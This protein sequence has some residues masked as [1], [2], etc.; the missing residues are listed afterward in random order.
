MIPKTRSI[1]ALASLAGAF[2]LAFAPGAS[3]KVVDNFDDNVK[4]GWTDA[5]FGIGSATETG[6]QLVFT[7]PAVQ[8]VFFA[9][10][11]NTEDYTLADGKTIEL[12]VDMISANRPDAY[13]ILA[14]IP[15]SVDVKSLAGYSIT[16]SPAAILV[17]K[18]INKY[19]IQEATPTLKQNNVTMVLTL[20][21]KGADVIINVKVLDKDANNAVVYEK[22]VIDTPAADALAAG[23]DSPAAPYMGAGKMTLM[24]YEDFNAGGDA[25]YT[26]TFDNAESFVYENAVIDDFNAGTKTGWTDASFGVGSS[27]VANGQFAFTI[28]AVQDVFFASLKN[29]R[30]YEFK[31]GEKLEFRVDLISGSRPDAYAIVSFTPDSVDPKSLQGYGFVK[32]S[33]AIL[34]SKGINKYFYQAAHPDIKNNNVTL[35]LNLERRGTSVIINTRIYDLEANNAVLFD[36]TFVDTDAADALAAGTDSP[37]AAYTGLGKFALMDYEDFNAGGGSYDVVFDNA[38]A[39]SPPLPANSAPT[40]TDIT[41]ASGSNFLPATT[42]IGFKVGDDNPLPGAGIKVI[43]NGVTYT[44]ANGLTLTANANQTTGSLGGLAANK[45]Y[46]ATIEA[47]DA[48]NAV[49]RTTFYFDTFTTN[50]LLVEVEDYN[51]GG[52]LFIDN[53]TIEPVGGGSDTAYRGQ[54]GVAEIDYHNNRGTYAAPYRPDRV[55]QIPTLDYA[56]EPYI[57]LGGA[58]NGFIDYNTSRINTGEWQRYTRTFAAG[59]YEVYLREAFLNVPT[60]ESVL[61]KVLGEPSDTEAPVELLGSFLGVNSGTLYRNIPLTDALGQTIQTVTFDGIT[62]LRLRHMTSEPNDGEIYQNYLLFVPTAPVTNRPRIASLSPTPGGTVESPEVLISATLQDRD[63]TVNTNTLELFINDVKA[64]AAISSPAPGTNVI[65]Y[66]ISPVPAS[67]STINGS[68]RYTDSASVRVTNN[69]SF[70]VTYPSLDAA[71][72]ISAGQDPGWRVRVVQAPAGSNLADSIVRAEDQLAA[73]STVPEAFE[74]S[75][76]SPVIN[77]NQSATGND[78]YF[79]SDIQFPGMAENPDN[80]TDDIAME[81]NAYL[82]L[83]AGIVRFGIVS[84]DG[85]KISAGNSLQAQAPV[86]STVSDDTANLTFDVYVP[87]AGIYPFRLVWY[88]RSG[89]AHVELFTVDRATG[90]RLLIGSDAAGAVKAYQNAAAV[91]ETI[92]L[93]SSADVTATFA[94]DATAVVNTANKTITVPLNGAARF[95]LVRSTGAAAIKITN[96]TISAGNVVLTYGAP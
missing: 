20:T 42:T 9:S 12:R 48:G 79:P 1:R 49:T 21:G 56:R 5:G 47:T 24:L 27:T 45:T 90:T 51:F 4:T 3:A 80:G 96:T 74:V 89:G 35:A 17:S 39:M 87:V 18:G 70:T 76:N 59:T 10:S 34:V 53:P 61:E 65:T 67:G 14:W 52:G 13:A 31:D 83:P 22:T 77:F 62:T 43:L 44:T 38:F 64:S 23:T 15:N 26:A 8:D 73:N 50:N 6:G 86:L 11:K 81:A 46:A 37:A 84:D 68:I 63:T 28:P 57:S 16:K 66:T 36:R 75:T 93:L 72:R 60:G 85:F 2:L 71:N 58:G 41:P 69:W 40:I 55:T 25:T 32:S 54:Q 82:E 30:S 33:A 91:T 7:I 78:G 92:T 95:Y 29:T 88:E 19:F 94:A